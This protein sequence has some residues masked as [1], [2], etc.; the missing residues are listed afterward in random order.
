MIRDREELRRTL[1]EEQQ[2]LLEQLQQAKT[3]TSESLGYGNHMADDATE[4]FDQAAGIAL[5]QNLEK[6]LRRVQE[7]LRRFD[8]G[9]Y[10]VCD[11]CR[12]PID[13]ARLEAL[14]YV[15]LCIQCQQRREYSKP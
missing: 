9:T 3:V 4:A 8:E 1:I 6:T 14:P 13:L 7:A 10:G 15:T 2:K 11:D 12:Q 5:R